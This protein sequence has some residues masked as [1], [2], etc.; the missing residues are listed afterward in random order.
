MK[1]LPEEIRE[2]RRRESDRKYQ[3]KKRALGLVKKTEESRI[4]RQKHPERARASSA[5]S[6]ALKKGKIKRQPCQICGAKYVYGHHEDYSKYYDVIW[7]CPSCHKKWHMGLV[8]LS[9]RNKIIK[10]C[11]MKKSRRK[12]PKKKL[13]Q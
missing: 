4:Y 7:L 10:I 3:A 5:L 9:T 1:K 8:D 12:L 6:K 13:L 11:Q 2:Q